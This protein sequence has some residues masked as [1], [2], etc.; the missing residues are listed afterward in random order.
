LLRAD[1]RKWQASF[2]GKYERQQQQQGVTPFTIAAAVA[3]IGHRV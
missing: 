1:G 3:R 2:A